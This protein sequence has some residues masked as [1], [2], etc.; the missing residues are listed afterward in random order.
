MNGRI[1]CCYL[2]ILRRKTRGLFARTTP[3]EAILGFSDSS[4]VPNVLNPAARTLFVQ[5]G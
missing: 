5:D 2:E 1:R 3:V 4:I